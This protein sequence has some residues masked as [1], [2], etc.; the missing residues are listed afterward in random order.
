MVDEF[1]A[2][3]YH[4]EYNL[5]VVVFRLFNTVGARQTGQYGMV[6]PRFVQQA[7]RGE[8]ITV[9]GDGGQSRCFLN[10][11]DAVAAIVA[12]A[13]EPGAVGQVFNIGS[14]EEVT[15][16]GLAQQVLNLV[17][18]GGDPD[19]RIVFVP[20][21][22]AYAVGFEDMRHRMPDTQKIHQ[23]INW[24]PH[25]NLVDTLNQVIEYYQ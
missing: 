8:S 5:P 15:I 19:A 24:Q 1:L 21:D 10:V 4:R 23:L 16:L 6:V 11:H 25:Y 18:N 13:E 17:D 7:L 12:L 9:Y 14:T 20:Y 3:A 2:L 22:Q